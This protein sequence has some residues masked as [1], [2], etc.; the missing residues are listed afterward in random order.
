[1][2]SS[3]ISL[4]P[5]SRGLSEKELEIL[6]GIFR[7]YPDLTTAI[8]FGSRAKG[9]QKHGSDVDLAVKG[10][11]LTL[12]TVLRIQSDIEESNLPYFFDVIDMSTIVSKE[13]LQHIREYGV[14]IYKKKSL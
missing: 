5:D 7:K 3:K 8:L 9:T 11:N 12:S 2:T 4:K 10:E 14:V 13:L 1:M 6:S